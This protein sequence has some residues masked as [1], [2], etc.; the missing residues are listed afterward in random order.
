MTNVIGQHAF[1][2]LSLRPLQSICVRHCPFLASL[3]ATMKSQYAEENW[4]IPTKHSM[5]AFF[6]NR[7]TQMYHPSSPDPLAR[8]PFTQIDDTFPVLCSS[9]SKGNPVCPPFPH[10][11]GDSRNDCPVLFS[12]TL[13]IMPMSIRREGDGSRLLMVEPVSEPPSAWCLEQPHL[14]NEPIAALFR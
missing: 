12:A 4:K 8:S 6:A 5:G 9:E 7:R 3:R 1:L 10:R 11:G 2:A 14:Q 13:D